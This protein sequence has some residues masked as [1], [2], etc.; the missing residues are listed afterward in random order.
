MTINNSIVTGSTGG[1]FS[2]TAYGSNNLNNLSDDGTV[3]GTIGA[4]TG[5]DPVL[6]DN[7]G[8]TLTH[9]LLPGSNA[10][11]AGNNS[12]LSA[13]TFDLNGNGNTTEPIPFDQRGLGFARIVNS[14]GGAT[15]DIGAFEFGAGAP[16]PPNRFVVTTAIDEDDGTAEPGQGT[17]T[18]LREAISAANITANEAG[19]PDEIDFDI[20]GPGPHTIQVTSALPGIDDPVIINGYS[21]PGAGESIQIELNGVESGGDGLAIRAGQS[22][23]RGLS[24]HGFSGNGISIESGGGNRIQGNI[25]GAHAS[26]EPSPNGQAGILINYSAGNL[27]GGFEGTESNLIAFNG[28]AGVAI[29]ANFG[30]GAGIGTVVEASVNNSILSNSIHSN[31]SLGIDFVNPCDDGNPLTADILDAILGCTHRD[32]EDGTGN[33]R[34]DVDLGPNNLQNFP[35]IT[36]AAIAA[37]SGQLAITYSVPSLNSPAHSN[38]PLTVE[39]FLADAS[40]REGRTLL[41]RDTYTEPLVPRTIGPFTP[42]AAVNINDVVVGTATDANGNTAEF[43]V[44]FS[45][46][47]LTPDAF[48]VTTAIDEDDGTPDPGQGTGTS[49]REAISAA[50]AN[51]NQTTITFDAGLN[52]EPLGGVQPLITLSIAGANEDNNATGDLDVLT[53]ITIQGNVAAI[54][55][56]TPS[57]FWQTNIDAG[58]LGDRVFHSIGNANLTLI[59]LLFEGGDAGSDNGGGVLNESGI[60][61]IDYNNIRKNLAR[62]GGGISNES[63]TV[64]IINSTVSDND[65]TGDGG[66][67]YNAAGSVTILESVR[68]FESNTAAR[69]GGVFNS[70]SLEVTT[71]DVTFNRANEGAGIYNDTGATATIL[72][73]GIVSNRSD[74]N[75]SGGIDNRGS[76]SVI[77]SS[78]IGNTAERGGGGIENR[79]SLVVTNSTISGNTGIVSGAFYN[80]GNLTVDSSTIFGNSADGGGV[81]GASYAGGFFDTFDSTLSVDNSIVSGNTGGDLS[82]LGFCRSGRNNLADDANF[83]GRIAAVTGLDPVLKDN[84]GPTPTHNLLPGSNAIDTGDSSSLPPDTLDLDGDGDRVEPIP[85]DQRG[86]GFGRIIDGGGGAIVD[87]GA[88]EI[89]PPDAFVVTTAIDEDDRTADPGQGTGTSIREAIGAANANPN[90]TTITFDQSLDGTPLV[91]SIRGNE[92]DDNA[93]GDLDV[94]FTTSI[95]GRGAQNTII[96]AGGAGGLGE[97]VFEI[98]RNGDVTVDG[99]TVTG[100]DEPV[101][102][103]AFSNRG[104]LRVNN[105]TIIGNSAKSGGGIFSS[106]GTVTVS[107]SIVT[108]NAA[109]TGGAFHLRNNFMVSVTGSTVSG[110]FAENSGGGFRSES[111]TLVV[112]NS[113]ISGNAAGVGGGG[114]LRIYGESGVLNN[115]IIAGNTAVGGPSDIEINAGIIDARNNL[116]GDP[117][118]AGGLLHGNNGNIVGNGAGGLL[119]ATSIFV[120][121]LPDGLIDE[122]DLADNGGPTLTHA[123][124]P[125][126]P[127]I[128]A[129]DNSLLPA[130]SE[131]Q[132]SDGDTTE[133]IPFDQRGTGFTRIL[134][135]ATVDIGAFELSSV[136][137][138]ASI[139]GQVFEDRNGNGVRDAGEVGTD[140]WTVELLETATYLVVG[141]VPSQSIDLDGNGQ[142]DPVTEQGLYSFTGLNEGEYQV[143]QI[144]TAFSRQTLPAIGG[145]A[146]V[147][148]SVGV[149]GMPAN[150]PSERPIISADGQSVVFSS[151][152][153]NIVEPVSPPDNSSKSLVLVNTATKAKQLVTHAIDVF[154]TATSADGRYV[155]FG[156]FADNV[157]P[158]DNDGAGD[159]FLFDSQTEMTQL[160]SVGLDDANGLSGERPAISAD[161]RYVSFNYAP[162]GSRAQIYLFDRDE[163]SEQNAVQL[164]TRGID[165]L[166]GNDF[167]QHSAIS[168]DGRYVVFLSHADNLVE[169]DTNGERDIFLYDQVTDRIRMISRGVDGEIADNFSFNPTISTDGRYVAFRSFADNLVIG[170]G[171]GEQDV[172]LVELGDPEIGQPDEIQ[173]VTAGSDG[174]IEG[175][176]IDPDLAISADGQYLAFS[177]PDGGDSYL[178]FFDR[179]EPSKTTRIDGFGQ[180]R[181]PSISADG[182]FVVFDTP[183]Q[184]AIPGDNNSTIDV[185]LF[186]REAPDRLQVVSGGVNG[187]VGDSFSTRPVISADGRYVA[188]DSAATNLV[189][190]DDT[191]GEL[192][193]FLHQLSPSTI[194]GPRNLTRQ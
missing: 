141:S 110:N 65:V 74:G 101:N 112:S 97:R 55:G 153:D 86:A 56:T 159:W 21:Q 50:N 146:T 5:F 42:P 190:D 108:G 78:L 172:F 24:I 160:I 49:L 125:G 132:D 185:F 7:G 158:G 192:D 8:P 186:D 53:D 168:A 44:G 107:N 87:I 80:D 94:R 181:V 52:I 34:D 100:G 134:G 37:L 105:S 84:R 164:V 148:L 128:D 174:F 143:R 73:T 33:D 91:L 179:E 175:F 161:G 15:V 149:D 121:V 157:V 30:N 166:L 191:N 162:I 59:D 13:D 126:S 23:I 150:G 38:Y 156:S 9:A 154:P 14:G 46:A 70:G 137:A 19:G 77:N 11:D 22:V 36:F 27:I 130:D 103:G 155:A 6:R 43:S 193:V 136:P 66:G 54:P 169:G 106:F 98:L 96:D 173:L 1:D 41:V 139:R 120:D 40:G 189:T 45:V 119:P 167:S 75:G 3:P 133:P 63:G 62:H 82:G 85:F 152:A 89:T 71:S 17:G 72:G 144:P 127:A 187:V 178:Y 117:G 18:L 61:I 177:F 2:G 4:A 90:R 83:P 182:R 114:G 142:I 69:G 10:I 47:E 176:F 12:L 92:E 68:G 131:D 58:G 188:F 48:V 20:S 104:T 123:L 31:A 88:V 194:C 32:V 147:L 29:V 113:T 116:I 16:A 111:T 64:H 180:P 57:P 81:R 135:R 151:F 67:V 184:S 118:S 51:P 79:G 35:E 183:F 60:L 129:G 109:F 171:D 124:L 39:F 115:T 138:G 76:A 95:Q 99:V 122:R 163:Q 28:G 25:V 140:G 165:G 26:G 145:P 102:G 170:D 93:T